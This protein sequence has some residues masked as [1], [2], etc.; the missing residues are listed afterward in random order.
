MGTCGKTARRCRRLRPC[1][2]RCDSSKLRPIF[3]PPL[4][5]LLL[6][7]LT[8]KI[9]RERT[10]NTTHTKHGIHGWIGLLSCCHRY[11]TRQT[12]LAT[13]AAVAVTR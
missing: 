10:A 2:A 8:T 3:L 9:G 13:C 12:R 1:Q 4:L 5:L 11:I 7:L 6:L